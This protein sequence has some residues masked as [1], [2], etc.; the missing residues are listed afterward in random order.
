MFVLLSYPATMVLAQDP[1]NI[2]DDTNS[3]ARSPRQPNTDHNNNDGF[4]TA[5][6]VQYHSS[7]TTHI[8]TC[9]VGGSDTTDFWRLDVDRGTH[10]YNNNEVEST[11]DP[12]HIIII[13]SFNE[14]NQP[15]NGIY[16]TLY[17]HD[18]HKLGVSD[19][20]I[21]G[22]PNVIEVI[23]QV[24]Q[25]MY[26]EVR[27]NPSTSNFK[28][29]LSIIDDTIPTNP[30]Y[31]NNE[32]FDTAVDVNLTAGK[33]FND[34]E[35]YLDKG[36][37]F[38]DFYKFNA[39]VNQKIEIDLTMS[40]LHDDFDLFLYDGKDV[41]KRVASSEKI[42]QSERIV[43]FSPAEKLYYLRVGVKNVLDEDLRNQG[44]YKLTLRGNI[45]PQW[46]ASFPDKYIMYEDGN[47]LFIDLPQAYYELNVGDQDLIKIQVWDHSSGQTG[48]WTEV[49][50]SITYGNVTVTQ[51][52]D[53]SIKVTPRKN[54]FGTDIIKVRATDD[55]EENYTYRDLKIIV[56]PTND[57][58]IL[59]GTNRWLISGG[60][61]PSN[62][63][64]RITGKE[65]QNFECFVTAHEPYDPWDSIILS[66][67]TDLFDINP[68]SGKISFLA[69]YHFTGTHKIE[70]TAQDN[71]TPAMNTTR[72]FKFIIEP[73]ESYPE[74]ELVNPTHGSIQFS[75]FPQFTWRQINPEFEDATIN[76]DV[77]LSSTR[78][79]IETL[80][81]SVLVASIQD[82]SAYVPANG[83]DDK[84]KY[85]W[86]VIPNDGLHLGKCKSGI[87]SFETNTK[88]ERPIVTLKSPYNNQM[89]LTDT[90]TLNWGLEYDG[91]DKVSY[92]VYFGVSL[93]E[94]E[95]PL[96][97]PR[98]T[99][100]KKSYEVKNLYYNRYY[101]WKIRP[102]TD[103]VQG[104]YSDIFSFYLAEHAP[105][106]ELNSPNNNSIILPQ[107]KIVLSWGINYTHPKQITCILYWG[108]SPTFKDVKGID[109]GNNRTYTATGLEKRSYYWKVVPYLDDLR[110]PE[111][112]TW[113]F[114]MKEISVPSAIL[115]SPINTKL[116]S[117]VVT[118]EWH[119]E[120]DGYYDPEDIWYEIYL[121]N[122][123]NVVGE[124]NRLPLD[125]YQQTF[126]NV[127]LP[128]EENKTYYWY[129]IPHL[130]TDEG[131]ITGECSNGVVYFTF[132]EPD[133]IFLLNMNVETNSISI[134]REARKV[135]NFIVKNLGNQKTTVELSVFSD[136]EGVLNPTLS[137]TI[138]ILNAG[139]SENLT[140]D[141]NIFSN[142]ELKTYN[143]TVKATA[144]ESTAVYVQKTVTLTVTDDSV[145]HT[146]GKK[147][148]KSDDSMLI[149]LIVIIIIIIVVILALF[150]IMKK[151]KEE[152]EKRK[153]EREAES[154]DSRVEKPSPYTTGTDSFSTTGQIKPL[155][156]SVTPVQPAK[157]A[158]KTITPVTPITPVQPAPTKPTLPPAGK[159]ES[160]SPAVKPAAA[161]PAVAKPAVQAT[162][163]AKPVAAKPVQAKPVQAQPATAK[164]VQA[165]AKPA[166][167]KPA[168][169][170]QKK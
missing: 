132:G 159:I 129:V 30:A 70:I 7:G 80:D 10:N 167:A 65:G 28:Y 22:D 49:F 89:V 62:D 170:E 72:E 15:G 81:K 125:N 112:E 79:Q 14:T 137:K 95:D 9:S 36:Y 59:N 2:N 44:T 123:T 11:S 107:D 154:K 91:D 12:V 19:I 40:P 25:F 144:Q 160:A 155:S 140:L 41:S 75:L 92:D 17:D 61:T 93:E 146:D 136:G 133:M 74:V 113:V 60:L 141:I 1:N 63:G 45:P 64:I 76:Y 3:N 56:K 67:N 53:G 83:L 106:I 134:E 66:D 150:L 151:K 99:V 5:S 117:E 71:G 84:T 57:A 13:N 147:E 26:I 58:P 158:A 119:M 139:Q 6:I 86:T 126:Y 54:K 135:I 165:Q 122:S 18:H 77:Y 50:D 94:M 35:Q 110:G 118:L 33:V 120:Y 100:T 153:K 166:A 8:Q 131:A 31:A 142:A 98:A 20:A 55:L 85:Y 87:F 32:K 68:N 27:S 96:V 161:K 103:K 102:F 138:T 101:F 121:D 82:D 143:V 21:E 169:S 157:P 114:S 23:A 73:S 156:V 111:S 38:A 90:Q 152:A 39:S 104:N 46:N 162:V 51:R 128:F 149:I 105:K 34:E 108:I 43:F 130:R 16:M 127:F 52:M 109:L 24:N 115:H 48:E 145:T 29:I 116:Y 124:M 163:K 4:S 47:K 97:E 164:P 88:I 168:E 42:G 69:T 78:T 148:S 37:D